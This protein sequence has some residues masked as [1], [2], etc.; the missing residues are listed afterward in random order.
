MTIN[1]KPAFMKGLLHLKRNE[2]ILLLAFIL[3]V[4]LIG[5]YSVNRVK[6]DSLRTIRTSL[7]TINNSCDEALTQWLNFRR[8]NIR[9]LSRNNYL[10]RK[11]VELERL[12]PEASILLSSPHTQELR[13]F[14]QPI[15]D[16]NED[17]G[18]FLITHDYTSI[19]SMRDVNTGS[20]NLMAVQSKKLLD[21][22][23]HE[24]KIVLIPPI[25][26][27]VVL[28]SKYDSI[29]RHTMFLVAPIVYKNK[30]IAA[31]SLRLDIHKDF[32]RILELGKVGETGETYGFDRAA[33]MVTLSRFESEIKQNGKLKKNEHSITNVTVP[34]PVLESGITDSVQH[35]KHKDHVHRLIEMRD[36]RGHIVFA[37]SHWNKALNIG[38]LTKIDRS[39]ALQE[40]ITVRN[41]LIITFILLLFLVFVVMSIIVNLRQKA[42]TLLIKAN[43]ELEEKVA[44]RTRELQQSIAVK[45]KF[46]SILAHDL[47][48]P[49]SGYLGLF[50][51]MVNNPD[52]LSED[53]KNNVIHQMYHSGNQLYRLLENLLNWSRSQTNNISLNPEKIPVQ[54][55]I[56]EIILLKLSQAGEKNIKLVN[57]VRNDVCLFGDRNTLQT[58]FR[59]LISNALKFTGEWGEVTVTARV[60]KD[61]VRVSVQD[62]GVGIPEDILDKLFRID[63]KISTRGTGNEE[64]TGLGL[65]LCKEFVALNNGKISVESKTGLGSTFV[66]ELPSCS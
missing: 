44:Q 32:S 53:K 49:F 15:L 33:K 41:I 5:I 2:Y 8:D 16:A 57:K 54:E 61:R 52:A 63:E 26:S 24:G 27:D 40:F 64:G 56:G 19:F 62:N 21:R 47:R 3:L 34:V 35:A 60:V 50:E 29:T 10:I 6:K 37:V 59:N 1:P 31:F 7:V 13:E 46:F 39:E 9:D 11:T 38:I 12:K 36:T 48:S 45:D 14:F 42:E 28:N 51:L 66:V 22:V 4:A 58:V 43:V 17:L 65:I 55:L 23:L 20:K 30:V 25:H 18:V